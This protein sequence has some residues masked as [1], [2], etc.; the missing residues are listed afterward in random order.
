MR[1]RAAEAVPEL[2]AAAKAGGSAS[3][4]VNLGKAYAVLGRFPDAEREFR[5]ALALEPANSVA[6]QALRELGVAR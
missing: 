3:G 4:R 2:E 1:G 5:Q 6:Q